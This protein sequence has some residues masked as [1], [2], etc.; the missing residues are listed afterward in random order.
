MFGTVFASSGD[1][2]CILVAVART[3]AGLFKFALFSHRV[4]TF[5]LMCSTTV[6]LPAMESH[7]NP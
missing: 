2:I 4:I 5:V 3:A 1:L 6:H 7:T